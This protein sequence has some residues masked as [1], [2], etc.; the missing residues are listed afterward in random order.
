MS[1][2]FWKDLIFLIKNTAATNLCSAVSMA[3]TS[4]RGNKAQ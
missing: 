4:D 1:R 3:Q 2:V